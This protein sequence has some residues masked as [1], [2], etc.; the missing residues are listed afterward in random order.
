MDRLSVHTHPLLLL[1]SLSL[2]RLLCLS[3]LGGTCSTSMHDSSP[4][5]LQD[6]SPLFLLLLTTTSLATCQSYYYIVDTYDNK[7]GL[8]FPTGTVKGTN[9]AGYS[10]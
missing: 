1:L 7:N 2:S 6:G 5:L 4:L 9:S 10:I 8:D 3:E